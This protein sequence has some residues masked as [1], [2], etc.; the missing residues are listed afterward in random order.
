MESFPRQQVP[1][2]TVAGKN[3]LSGVT[4]I[5]LLRIVLNVFIIFLTHPKP[6][7]RTDGTFLSLCHQADE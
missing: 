5:Y 1:L 3:T 7:L 2:N 6:F 4:N